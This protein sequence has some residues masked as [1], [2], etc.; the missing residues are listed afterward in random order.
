MKS[1]DFQPTL[2][3]EQYS[4]RPLRKSDYHNLFLVAGDKLL[5]A[6]HPSKN[7]YKEAEFK[8]WFESALSSGRALVILDE[9]THT[10]IGSTRFYVA[11]NTPNDISIGY[12]FISRHYWGG[13]ANASIK[14]LMITYAS[15]WFDVIWFHISPSN[16]R[17][18]KATEKIG[19]TF[20]AKEVLDLGRG[21]EAWMSYQYIVAT[22][23]SNS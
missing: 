17:S 22:P 7:R 19:A 20:F 14:Q 12:T 18:Q 13:A 21:E 4:L 16:I 6:G 2:V 10:V 8:A 11:P 9:I 23:L 1:F 5:W 15:Q 3:G